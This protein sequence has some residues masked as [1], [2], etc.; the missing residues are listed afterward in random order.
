MIKLAGWIAIGIS[1]KNSIIN[2]KYT[3]NYNNIGHGS[4]LISANGYSWSHSLKD[5]NSTNKSFTFATGDTI[6][7]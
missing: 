1:L 4:Y 6:Y 5:F 2:S 7:L 3:F